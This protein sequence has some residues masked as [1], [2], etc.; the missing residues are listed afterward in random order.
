MLRFLLPAAEIE[1]QL[2]QQGFDAQDGIEDIQHPERVEQKKQHDERCVQGVQEGQ[3]FHGMT[4][5]GGLINV[6]D[7]QDIDEEQKE[8]YDQD[9]FEEEDIKMPHHPLGHLIVQGPYF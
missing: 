8:D 2:S 1:V 7:L 4:V 9:D 5:T 3:P 6:D